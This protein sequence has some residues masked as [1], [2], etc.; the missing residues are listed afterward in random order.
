M[1]AQGCY[2]TQEEGAR[3]RNLNKDFTKKEFKKKAAV[4]ARKAG[5][6]DQSLRLLGWFLLCLVLI[7]FFLT[8]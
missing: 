1:I 2:L 7:P 3:H 5:L 4:G 8:G 6:A